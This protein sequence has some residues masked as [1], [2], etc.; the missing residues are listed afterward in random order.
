MRS[1]LTAPT[2]PIETLNLDH[3][4]RLTDGVGMYQHATGST[5]NPLHGYCVDDNARALIV[6]IRAQALTGRQDLGEY[7][8]RFLA[9]LVESQRPDGLFHNFMSA[10][11]AWLDD[12]GSQDSQG[13]AVWGL[14]FA[15]AK[16]PQADVQACALECLARALP[17]L[18]E[19][20][21]LR[22]QAFARLG[23]G[24][25]QKA[26]PSQL[27][28]EL[29]QHFGSSLSAA[30]RNC[31]GPGWKWF[32][33]VLTYCNASLPEA[34]LDGA[35]GHIATQSL[36][37][38]CETLEHDGQMH[39]VGNDGWYPRDGWPAPFDQQPVD[40]ASLVSACAAQFR[41]SGDA[42]FRRWATLSF[43][44][45]LGNNAGGQLM[46]DPFTG[47]CY[48][49]LRPDGVNLNQGAESLLSWLSSQ[50]EIVEMG[51]S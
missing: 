4:F 45:F 39:L 14:G 6:A 17:R 19:L 21:A 3:L 13:R 33:D 36:T 30:Y 7:V 11:A 22:A 46:V 10:G 29:A 47:G 27:V 20:T 26:R 28:A 32:E 23:L 37:W 12:V 31:E 40:A 24:L 8:G 50:E 38:L 25:W 44:W 15:A 49:G 35:R 2:A 51:W 41:L 16:S 1:G 18:G 42:R 34:L 43:E 48:D 9:F 5:P